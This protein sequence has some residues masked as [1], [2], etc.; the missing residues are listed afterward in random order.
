VVASVQFHVLGPLRVLCD[1]GEPVPLAGQRQRRTLAVLLLMPN[2]TVGLRQ[3]I[4]AVWDD[5]PPATA[6][7]QI[8]NCVSGLRRQLA[9]IGAA[10]R[11][12]VVD[13]AG[14][15]IRLSNGQL[16]A[17]VFRDLSVR[18]RAMAAAGNTE[19]AVDAFRAALRLWRGPALAGL[20]GRAIEAGAARLD[21]QRLAVL[22]DCVDLEL[23][24]G[25]E[26]ELIGELTEVVAGSPLRERLVGQL[27]TALYRS[28]RQ[29]DA[30]RKYQALR[31]R[32]SDELG[33]DPSTD[34]Q[35]LHTAILRNEGSGGNGIH[36]LGV[37]VGVGDGTAGTVTGI[38]G[39]DGWR[40]NQL[41]RDVGDFTGRGHQMAELI[42][43]LA[44]R[45]PGAAVAA[46]FGKPG[47][48]KTA[49]AVHVGH[50][51][52]GEFPDGQL[53]LNLGGMGGRPVPA[54]EALMRI[55][56][57][58]G[59][60]RAE[61]PRRSEA[62]AEMYRAHLATRRLLI[63]LDNVADEAQVRPLLP[64]GTGSA[65]LITSRRALA[66][67][68][69]AHR[70]SLV[71]LNRDESI[72]LLRRVAGPARLASTPE[73]ADRIVE[74]CDRLP[75][76]IR[77]AGAKLALKAHWSLW[78]LV[79]RLTGEQRRLDELQV[80]DLGV[81]ASFSLSYQALDPPTQQLFG[82]L[83]LLHTVDFPAWVPAT[84]VGRPVADVRDALERLVD[85]QLLDVA[86][87]DPAGRHRYRLHDLLAVFARER[88]RSAGA[89]A[90]KQVGLGR[91]VGGWLAVVDS[92]EARLVVSTEAANRSTRQPATAY[93]LGW[94]PSQLA[95]LRTAAPDS[96][97]AVWEVGWAA[98]ATLV[99][100]SFELWS[101]WDDWRMTRDAA[102][103]A[104]HRVGDRLVEGS[105]PGEFRV[106]LGRTDPWS[107][108]V[109]ELEAG[110][111]IFEELGEWRW[112][113]A[114]IVSLGNLYRAQGSYERGVSTLRRGVGLFHDLDHPGWEAAALFS[115]ASLHVVD[116]RLADAVARYHDCKA[117]F[118]RL[119][120]RLWQAHTLRA[121]GYAYQQHGEYADAAASLRR[122]LPVLREQDDPIWAAHTQLTLARAELGM[123][124]SEDALKHLDACIAA[125]RQRGD[126]RSEAMALRTLAGAAGRHDPDTAIALLGDCLRLFRQLEDPV[127]VAH[128]LHDIAAQHRALGRND[129]ASRHDRSCRA[130]CRDLGLGQ[131][132]PR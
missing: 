78:E 122:C 94:L 69:A 128:T 127:G 10:E 3:L 123:G 21:E 107:D 1:G 43:S 131:W 71:E 68:E 28:G 65:A 104:A 56:H 129:Q 113:A 121:L 30:L 23:R 58:L 50:R 24:L 60:G 31:K 97:A 59:V 93:P 19:G 18:G 89:V 27:M 7:R 8:Q 105:R 16:D 76:A 74:L 35:R 132:D 61:I 13:G 82:T 67:L 88:L 96:P 73:A 62:R 92:M 99:A 11:T 110:A 38:A 70:L 2:R 103:V 72:E 32:L 6:K 77:I 115:L 83:G 49:L 80:G 125:F 29:A 63:V 47:V 46:I 4:D 66:G 14:Y 25:R 81:R 79:D 52:C 101:H 130:L 75:L 42:S 22:A 126:F 36:T 34:L 37:G 114:M 5:R 106:I 91:A 116:G 95:A 108:V 86:R 118:Q 119:D 15:L 12:I 100:V 53:F 120:D 84:M 33:V 45:V 117:I 51:L 48:G 39:D 102:L 54:D 26:Q 112:H 40:R 64:A 111:S 87:R 44:A 98:T 85:A 57:L 109:A 9:L 17:D 55:L 90:E 124:R 41:P 20:A